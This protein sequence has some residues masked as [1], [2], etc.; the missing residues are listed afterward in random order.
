MREA[1][2]RLMAQIEGGADALVVDLPGAA[3]PLIDAAAEHWAAQATVISVAS[4]TIE[5]SLSSLI[6][7]ISGCTDLGGQDD[8]ALE[9]GFQRLTGPGE[10]ILLVT[11]PL[12]ISRSALRYLQHT[13]RQAPRLRLVMLASASL[14]ALLD[15]S[16]FAP[17]RLRLPSAL[18]IA[19][20]D[21]PAAPAAAALVPHVAPIAAVVPIRPARRHRSL[22][23]AGSMAAAAVL[24]SIAW[25]GHGATRAAADASHPIGRPPIARQP[26]V[27]AS[28]PSAPLGRSEPP[29]LAAVAPADLAVPAQNPAR[30]ER[31]A[32]PVLALIV[33]PLAPAPDYPRLAESGLLP[34][35]PAPLAHRPLLARRDVVHLARPRP[36]WQPRPT[37]GVANY[38]WGWPYEEPPPDWGPPNRRRR[39]PYFGPDAIDSYGRTMFGYSP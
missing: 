9:L 39:I 38:A 25:V 36:R 4:P 37:E 32:A 23:W 19:M 15:K 8:S 29:S 27:M 21:E 11:A 31:D 13:A 20:Q 3:G 34:P 18:P 1:L 30:V 2:H 35:L 28:V 22:L 5:L 17:L 26:I 33:P 7:Q 12:G 16:D 14:D 10:T 6:A 24:F